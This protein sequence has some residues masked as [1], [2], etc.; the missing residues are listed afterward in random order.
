MDRQ[1]I[2]LTAAEIA[3]LWTAYMNDSMSK[4]ILSHMVKHI[5]DEDIKGAIQFAL[6]VSL[7]HLEL[8]Y[9]L[10]KKEQ[11]AVPNGFTEE[12]VNVNAPWLFT[13]E[14]CLTYVNQM[15]KVGML[16]YSGFIATSIREDIRNYFTEGL[17]QVI[18]LYNQTTETALHKGIAARPPYIGVPKETDYI[19]SKAYLSGLN[20]FS[21]KR[22]LSAI[23]ITHLYMNILTNSMGIKLC[24]AFAQTSPSEE[25]QEFMLRGKDISQKH[26]EILTA[27]LLDENIET[28]HLPD[29]AISNSTA[30]TFSDKLLMFHMSLLSAAGIGN[31]AAAAAASQR[32]D[33]IMDYERLSVEIAKYTKSGADIMIK[34]GWLEQP[35]GIKDRERLAKQKEGY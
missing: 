6:D 24:L 30:P 22:P 32:S 1:H 8:L 10:F 33:L 21:K 20:P 2:H 9:T 28:P 12:D 25:V 23:E 18:S 27:V 3:S 17:T 35:P 15:A 13:E 19:D 16:A 26:M 7:G 11:Y 5:Q 4:C 31:Y 14:F 34:H 29:L